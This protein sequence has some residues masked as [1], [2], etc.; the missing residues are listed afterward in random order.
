MGMNFPSDDR[1]VRFTFADTHRV[2][3]LLREFLPADLLAHLDLARLKRL[4]ENQIRDTLRECRD[5]LNLE[6]PM[7]PDGRVR[8][9]ILVE[10]KS[11]HAPELWLQLMRA[12]CAEWENGDMTPVIPVVLH[13]GPERFRFE[14]PQSR[15]CDLPAP[16]L[17]S[18]PQLEIYA[19]DLSQCAQARI[20]DSP[21]LDHVS[22][23]AL[24]ILKLAQ[25]RGLDIGEIRAVLRREGPGLSEYRRRRYIQAAISY[26]HYKSETDRATLKSLGRD[27]ALV[28]P[29]NPKSPFAQELREERQKGLEQG[30]QRGQEL[31]EQ[32]RL[33]VIRGMLDK[34]FDWVTIESIV[35]LDQAGYELLKA[36][37]GVPE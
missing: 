21:N 17:A 27:M 30:L 29:I 15:L 26:L 16:L 8:I 3:G 4:H 25:Q 33:D 20:W 11:S 13:T 35:H 5:D 10:H 23:V 14:T 32:G 7:I 1:Y 24:T 18:L 22:K 31:V 12:L 28:H 37:L 6:C 34:G 2:A 36:K 19:I 9:R